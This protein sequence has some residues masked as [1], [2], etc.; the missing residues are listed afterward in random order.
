MFLIL[1]F[2][3]FQSQDSLTYSEGYKK[4]SSYVNGV[5]IASAC[6]LSAATVCYLF[7]REPN[8]S[9]VFCIGDMYASFEK[10]LDDNVVYDLRG[11]LQHLE[12]FNMHAFEQV[13]SRER[14]IIARYDSYI[15]PWNWSYDMYLAFHKIRVI[16]TLKRYASLFEVAHSPEDMAI[17]ARRAASVFEYYPCNAYLAELSAQTYYISSNCDILSVDKPG[18]LALEMLSLLREAAASLQSSKEYFEELG[19]MRRMALQE[20]QLEIQQKQLRELQAL[21]KKIQ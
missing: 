3:L 20:N 5:A 7:E 8:S 9:I 15:K 4:D 21:N 12:I 16:A 14:Q 13:F 6:L 19:E 18:R 2:F 10:Y 1:F 11:L 17:C